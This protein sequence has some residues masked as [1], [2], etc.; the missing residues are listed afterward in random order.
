MDTWIER[1]ARHGLEHHGPRLAQ[2]H[3]PTCNLLVAF[4]KR[5]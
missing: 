1:L 3:D 4:E 5:A 2:D